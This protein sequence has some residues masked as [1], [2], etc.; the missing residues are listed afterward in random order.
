MPMRLP[1]GT[2]IPSYFGAETMGTTTAPNSF[3]NVAL[4][5]GEV[6][7]IIY[8]NDPKNL[9]KT[10]V[11]YHVAVQVRDGTGPAAIV[12]YPNCQVAN[13]FGGTADRLRYTYRPQTHEPEKRQVLSD[14]SKVMV[15]CINGETRRAYIVGGLN[16]DTTPEKAEDG[17]NLRF[18]FNGVQVTI[19]KDGELQAR[20]RGATKIDGTLADSADANAEGSTVTFTKEGGIR[21]STKDAQ[22]FLFL[23]HQNKKLSI[24]ADEQWQV[25]VNGSIDFTAGDTV[26]FK[27]AKTCTIEMD[28]RVYIKS[29][30]VHV[31]AATQA[32]M[33]GTNY[34][35]SESVM[36]KTMQGILDGIATDLT[37]AASNLQIAA[38][39]H[40]IPV[41][42]PV[43]AAANLQIAATALQGLGPKFLALS[44][45][46]KI[47]ESRSSTFLSTKNR[48][49]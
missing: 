8:P 28:D 15:L 32:W 34:R 5:Q 4:R 47:H 39:M 26:K 17:H 43:Q 45:S 9:S 23:D 10:V 24:L 36:H 40:T 31:G 11:E 16:E 48:N 21:L 42:G 38:T 44:A 22:Q 19:N 27:G 13:L 33:M 12:N 25:D 46:I 37:L 18:E 3:G 2:V 14:G 6:R 35:N 41:Q 29:A 30:G 49:D 7:A 20:F 1:D